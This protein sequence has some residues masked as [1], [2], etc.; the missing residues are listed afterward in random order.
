MVDFLH[1]HQNTFIFQ[2]DFDK[3]PKLCKISSLSSQT[4]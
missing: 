1:N 3:K 2:A 4:W